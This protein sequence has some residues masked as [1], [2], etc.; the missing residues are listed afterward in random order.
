M[1]D[2][3]ANTEVILE[4]L[5][6]V[7]KRQDATNKKLDDLNGCVRDTQIK[8]HINNEKIAANKDDIDR[9]E[10]RVNAWGSINSVG[11][12]LGML[13]GYLGINK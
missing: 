9:I 10:G 11:A 2:A 4:R 5:D 13:L 1:A 6:A 7:I 8:V 12:V 3:A